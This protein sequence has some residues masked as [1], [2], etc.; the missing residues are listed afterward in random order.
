[1]SYKTSLLLMVLL[2]STK[3]FSQIR[4]VLS[5]ALNENYYEFR[6]QQ[7]QQTFGIL[8]SFGYTNPYVVEAV[9]KQG[10]T[11]LDDYT[12]N[13]FYASTNILGL[14]NYGI[15]E[16][17]TM[18]EGL[19]YFN[20]NDEDMIIKMTGRYQPINDTFFKIIEQNPHIDVFIKVNKEGYIFTLA[21]AMRCKYMKEM[22]AG[23]DYAS[24]E[25]NII[26]VEITAGNYV[27]QKKLTHHI[28]VMYIDRLH[29]HAN[30]YGS[31]LGSI[32]TDLWVDW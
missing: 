31:S 10:P 25:R 13:A 4:L 5:A 3:S 11:F 26:N 1:M 2:I 28:K 21:F 23:M 20:F 27:K 12:N 24:M 7:Y 14:K 9:K 8:S 15:N 17:R 6:K 19:Q 29:F 18:L 22:Y 30:L 16:A 32:N